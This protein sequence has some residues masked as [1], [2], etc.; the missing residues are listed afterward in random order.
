MRATPNLLVVP[1]SE[2]PSA[3]KIAE[4]LIELLCAV[5]GVGTG[6]VRQLWGMLI[7]TCAGNGSFHRSVRHLAGLP[8]PTAVR[9]ALQPLLGT[10][11]IEVWEERLNEALRARWLPFLLGQEVVLVGDETMIP[12]WG[13]VT[14]QLRDEVRGGQAKRGTKHFFGYLTVCALWGEQRVLLG[15]TRWRPGEP[16]AAAMA[17]IGEPLLE[18]GLRIDYWM[19]DRGA[20]QVAMFDWFWSHGQRFA[21]A[22]SRRGKKGGVAAILRSLEDERGWSKRCPRPCGQWYTMRPAEGAPVD[23]YLVVSWEAVKAQPGE[24]RQRSL[25][26][27]PARPGQRWRA[28][29]WFTDGS[30]WRRS[31]E[32]VQQR[33]RRRQSIESSYRMSHGCR[34]RTSSRDPLYR[35]LLFAISQLLQNEW[36]WYRHGWR[37][38]AKTPEAARKAHQWWFV[39][40]CFE[41]REAVVKWLQKRLKRWWSGVLLLRRRAAAAGGELV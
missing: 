13:K 4:G 10:L 7:H 21:V 40:F 36:S 35:L 6:G 22:A 23:L 8:S 14:K 20:D 26:R 32:A 19:W 28:V 1:P 25:R 5:C 15:V 41:V 17:R 37:S 11:S 16:L 24:R 2:P 3:A 31:G 27:A 29:A 12:Y 30:D 38:A 18:A 39:D 34:G 33:Y 9:G